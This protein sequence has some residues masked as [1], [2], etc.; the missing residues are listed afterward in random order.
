MK[1]TP[2]QNAVIYLLQNGWE[3]IT[4]GEMKG[5]IVGN[6]DHEFHINNGLFFRLVNKGLI[7]QNP[8]ADYWYTLTKDGENIK[9]KKIDL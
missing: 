7:F 2:K 4:N 9:N 8:Q 1:L 5:A 3:L 6:K